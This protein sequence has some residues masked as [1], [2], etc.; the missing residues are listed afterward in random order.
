MNVI[1]GKITVKETGK[2]IGDLLVVAFYLDQESLPKSAL[3]PHTRNDADELWH[4]ISGDRIGSVLTDENGWFELAYDDT[5]FKP[6]NRPGPSNLMLFVLASE[7]AG[8]GG[9]PTI[10]HVSYGTRQN[11]G[12]IE[13]FAIRLSLRVLVESGVSKRS[14]P[15][16]TAPVRGAR[17]FAKNLRSLKPEPSNTKGTRDT[18]SKRYKKWNELLQ[19]A[20]LATKRPL[21]RPASFH[22]EIEL[23][24]T[25]MK[26]L[27][28][29]L[30]ITL[31]RG[32]SRL[33]LKKDRKSKPVPLKF[34]GYKYTQDLKLAS[35]STGG[36]SFLVDREKSKFYL[37]IP[38]SPTR[39]SARDSSPDR[40]FAWR[41]VRLREE[42]VAQRAAKT[43]NLTVR[44]VDTKT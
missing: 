26:K 40:L 7:E 3:D 10:L 17:Q 32:N 30:K 12:R 20:N 27:P 41:A 6:R 22:R 29:G 14:L 13:T 35:V 4:A 2:G 37:C 34:G 31:D 1:Q 23:L 42:R 33:M 8:C 39:L 15:D 44:R 38:R 25:A 36:V 24:D 21:R 18:F 11:A 28:A 43:E 5:A 16:M 9:R 19:S